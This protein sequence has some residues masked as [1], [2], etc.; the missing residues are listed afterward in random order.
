MMLSQIAN[1]W[2][3]L[4]QSLTF[5]FNST[6]QPPKH[7]CQTD[8]S[9]CTRPHVSMTL[10]QHNIH[11]AVV[12]LFIVLKVTAL[13]VSFPALPAFGSHC[14]DM[15]WIVLG[16]WVRDGIVGSREAKSVCKVTHSW[17]QK[18]CSVHVQKNTIVNSYYFLLFVEKSYHAL[19]M[20]ERRYVCL[21]FSSVVFAIKKTV[22]YFLSSSLFL[23]K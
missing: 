23:L 2:T 18:S 7:R 11:L 19:R 12:W 1:F 6:S 13:A 8:N 10:Y 22:K 21:N 20:Y 5:F 16:V 15:T 9:C 4:D 3:K 14:C 17:S